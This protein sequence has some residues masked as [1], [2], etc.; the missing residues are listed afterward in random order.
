M[1]VPTECPRERLGSGGVTQR[2]DPLSTDDCTP[3][4]TCLRCGMP[5]IGRR[6]DTKWCSRKCGKAFWDEHN[7][8]R[9]NEHG[10]L[11]YERHRDELNAR[12]RQDRLASPERYRERDRLWRKSDA[13]RKWWA[14]YE[15]DKVVKAAGDR[16]YRES[17]RDE[18]TAYFREWT[19]NNRVRCR[20]YFHRRKALKVA[21]EG[22]ATA[23]KIQARVDF[24]GGRCWI[25][26]VPWE[27]I[28]H[29]KPLARGGSNWPANLRPACKRCNSSKKSTWPYTPPAYLRDRLGVL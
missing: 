24:Y 5:I 9:K 20:A 21:A 2:S 16:A 13:S 18:A 4:K 11:Y 3:T 14:T 26:G 17:H 19:R 10:R 12:V 15:R 28:D 27:Q 29:V 25:C 23:E 22:H 8:E 1:A 7:H 6:S